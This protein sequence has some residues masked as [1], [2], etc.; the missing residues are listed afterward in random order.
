MYPTTVG[1]SS[2]PVSYDLQTVQENRQGRWTACVG[3]AP[4][5]AALLRIR[6]ASERLPGGNA[7]KGARTFIAENYSALFGSGYTGRQRGVREG[8]DHPLQFVKLLLA[9][10]S[11]Q[12]ILFCRHPDYTFMDMQDIFVGKVVLGMKRFAFDREYTPLSL[13]SRV[14]LG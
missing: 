3:V 4:Y 13:A 7:A 1:R 5:A 9:G 10:T 12:Q 11:C 8:Q 6:S 2:N 14:Y